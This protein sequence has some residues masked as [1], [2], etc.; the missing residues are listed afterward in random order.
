M[1][2]AAAQ[3]RQCA[4]ARS[5]GVGPANLAGAERKRK[6]TQAATGFSQRGWR[7]ILEDMRRDP[8]LSIL[9]LASEPNAAAEVAVGASGMG[10]IASSPRADE[11]FAEAA[12]RLRPDVVLIQAG[13]PELRR[14]RTFAVLRGVDAG[15]VVFNPG[16][17]PRSRLILEWANRSHRS[18]AARQLTA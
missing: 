1:S 14:P 8:R 2:D 13:S 10:C 7:P 16:C 6:P 18:R 4:L 15:L 11:S 12:F 5:L 17:V 3:R 9:I